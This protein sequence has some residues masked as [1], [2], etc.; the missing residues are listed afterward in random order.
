[1]K[2]DVD[3]LAVD[4]RAL[5]ESHSGLR[6]EYR[7]MVKQYFELEARVRRLEDALL[8]DGK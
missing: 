7:E 3:H 8:G 5:L 4:V 2:P 6:V 1:M